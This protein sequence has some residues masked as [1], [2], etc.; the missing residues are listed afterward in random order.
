MIEPFAAPDIA[1]RYKVSP[2]F[3]SRYARM[4][5][6]RIRDMPTENGQHDPQP[7]QVGISARQCALF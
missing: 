4:S 2:P 6:N 5:I 1:M 7:Q 3:R